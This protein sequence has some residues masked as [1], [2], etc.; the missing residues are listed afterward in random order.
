MCVCVYI[1]IGGA[2][3]LKTLTRSRAR[4]EAM[5]YILGLGTEY[6]L[7][8]RELVVIISALETLLR[9]KYRCIIVLI[10]N[11]AAVLVL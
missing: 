2:I 6:N 8:S 1:G 10:R 9:F 3:E 7:Y 4:T 5:L 11:K